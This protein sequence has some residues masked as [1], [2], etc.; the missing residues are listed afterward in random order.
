MVDEIIGKMTIIFGCMNKSYFRIHIQG[1]NLAWATIHQRQ[2]GQL[3]VI[4]EMNSTLLNSGTWGPLG[5]NNVS[6]PDDSYYKERI[7][8]IY[9]SQYP[10]IFCFKTLEIIELDELSY[11]GS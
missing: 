1:K 8:E 4:P 2:T 10:E 3:E 6:I 11:S 7:L 5:L 9:R